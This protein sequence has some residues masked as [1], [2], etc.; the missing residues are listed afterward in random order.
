MAKI[1]LGFVG[2]IAS[3]KGTACKYLQKKHNAGY[4]RFSSI[5]RGILDRIYIEHS[6]ES[7][8]GVSTALRQ[9]FGDDILAEVMAK[10]VKADPAEIV[11]VD[12]IR[13][14]ADI[15]E[16]TKLP[17]FK[18]IHVTADEKIRY[19]RII[20]RTENIDDQNKTFEEFQADQKREAEITI[21]EVAKDADY[22]ITNNGSF[23]DLEKQI[24][25]TLTKIKNES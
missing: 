22:K 24:E 3:G 23:E 12:G 11:C 13:R 2:E 5:L 16:L 17:E 6:R 1:I 18:L 4:H 9:A 15:K 7:L 10:E 25:E 19:E 20:K 21:Y 8:Q 14:H